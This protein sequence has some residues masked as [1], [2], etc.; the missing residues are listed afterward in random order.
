M[1]WITQHILETLAILGFIG[2]I[3]LISIKIG[4]FTR[5]LEYLEKRM[6]NSEITSNKLMIDVTNIKTLKERISRVEGYFDTSINEKMKRGE[7]PISL[8]PYA[9]Q[10]LKDIEFDKIFD[11]M[12]EELCKRLDA[13]NLHTKYDV[14][15][16]SDYLMRE[17]RDDT[18]CDLLKSA[19][20][21]KGYN[22]DEILAAASIPLRDY[23]LSIH[24]EIKD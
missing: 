17:I 5:S 15:E 19:A 22:L 4:Y 6:D 12:K 2:S 23:Y 14:Q 24:P 8:T 3:F 11:S 20:F 10:V 9:I 21:T 13:F 1:E 16:M 18:L 7:S